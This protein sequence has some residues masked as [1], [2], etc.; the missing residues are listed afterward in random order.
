MSNYFNFNCVE[1]KGFLELHTFIE[2]KKIL[3][4]CNKPFSE[5]LQS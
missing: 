5:A 2:A 4:D 1:C 3:C